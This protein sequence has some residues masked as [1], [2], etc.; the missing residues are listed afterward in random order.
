MSIC[1][2]NHK[3]PFV[4][5]R[6]CKIFSCYCLVA[7]ASTRCCKCL[8]R[9]RILTFSINSINS[10]TVC[11]SVDLNK[12]WKSRICRWCITYNFWSRLFIINPDNFSCLRCFFCYFFFFWNIT[13]FIFKN[14]ISKNFHWTKNPKQ[15]YNNCYN[16]P[17]NNQT[18]I[19]AKPA[20]SSSQIFIIN[21]TF[22]HK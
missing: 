5:I 22:A 1:T 21:I 3:P 2:V 18:Q 10:Y 13:I 9:N 7:F 8:N 20:F 16:C 14:S 11:C 19:P 12:I 6:S 17:Y 15:N 4:F